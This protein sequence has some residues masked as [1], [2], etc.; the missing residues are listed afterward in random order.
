[1]TEE[2][3]GLIG[4]ALKIESEDENYLITLRID[5]AQALRMPPSSLEDKVFIAA[6]LFREN[7]NSSPSEEQIANAKFY[8]VME[9]P[10]EYFSR[11]VRIV[12]EESYGVNFEYSEGK[13]ADHELR[14]LVPNVVVKGGNHE[15]G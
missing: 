3:K 4:K 6:S 1:M 14:K 9:V 11:E 8:L 13:S 7:F 15:S 12:C 2:K 5:S 10:K